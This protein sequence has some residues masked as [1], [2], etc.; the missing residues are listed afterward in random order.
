VVRDEAYGPPSTNGTFPIGPTR[1]YF[2][3]HVIPNAED[4]S[5]GMGGPPRKLDYPSLLPPSDFTFP[6]ITDT[7]NFQLRACSHERNVIV[8]LIVFTVNPFC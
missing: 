4:P 2:S 1:D 6:Q 5:L 7:I 8:F 3:K